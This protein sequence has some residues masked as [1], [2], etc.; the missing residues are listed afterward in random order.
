M[1]GIAGLILKKNSE[2]PWS[3]RFKALSQLLQHRGPDGEGFMLANADSARAYCRIAPVS[4]SGVSG[5]YLN[6]M[7]LNTVPPDVKL[8][9]VH[10]R[11]SIIDLSEKARQPMSDASNR[12]WITYNGELYNY[13]ELRR[14]LQ[15]AGHTFYTES[16]TEVIL[17]AYQVW[18]ESCVNRF[19]GMWSFCIY[20]SQQQICFASRDRFGVKPFYYCNTSEYFAFASEQKALVGSGLCNSRV[21]E[22]ALHNYLVNGL[23]ETTEQN[24]F[25]SIYELRPGYNLRYNIKLQRYESKP[26][27]DL[28]SQIHRGND[29]LSEKDLIQQIREHF[30]RSVS[31]RLRSDVDVGTCLSGGI[32]SSAIA[33]SIAGAVKKPFY[34][35]TSVF[36][37]ETF[38]E[39]NFA[40]E[41]ARQCGAIQV[42]VEP[43][44][45]GFRKELDTL[46]YSQDVPIWDTSTYAQY[47]VMELAKLKGIKV[48]L[49]GQGADELFGGYHHHFLA[50]WNQMM[51]AGHYADA[52][53]SIQDSRKS[54][55]GPFRFYFK[56]RLKQ[57]RHFRKNDLGE[58][59]SKDFLTAYPLLNPS[60]RF[61][62]LNQ[63]LVNDIYETRLKS[64]LKCEDRCGMWHSV[65]SRVPFSDDIDLIL[66]LFSFD[67]GKKIQH[68]VSKYLLREA[69]KDLLPPL[70]YNR[71]DKKGFDTPMHSWLARMKSEMI[72]E[73]KDSKF[74]FVTGNSLDRIP[75]SNFYRY[76]ILFRLFVY[77]RWKKMF[78]TA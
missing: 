38:N 24:F 59:F 51:R 76:K 31:L 67:P 7:D 56:E 12:Y 46:I 53:R 8:G 3:E 19:N 77:S 43:S 21:N 32:D 17:M 36:R 52:I 68:G 30:L 15:N 39:E 29:K 5:T 60:A 14:E 37:T 11:L 65:E 33:V 20:D 41:V 13:I 1:C 54:I 23:L 48:V 25:A 22:A 45:E 74:S 64:F 58:M 42:K 66:L 75:E 72:R 63:Q 10:R 61:N 55:P 47:K 78:S 50:T 26:Y 34:C 49:D 69:L 62:D 16:D 70:I 71:H 4:V 27:F 18:G 28:A 6:P 9:F 40:D 44:L 73:V 35:F 57:S 2:F